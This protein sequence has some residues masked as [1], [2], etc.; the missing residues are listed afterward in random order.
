M[1]GKYLLKIFLG[2]AIV[3]IIACES[4]DDSPESSEQPAVVEDENQEVAPEEETE[5]S[6]YY[7]MS[8]Q[9][10][11]QVCGEAGFRY[12]FDGFVV[13]ECGACHHEDNI[14][15][16]SAFAQRDD[17]A[18]SFQV[19]SSGVVDSEAFKKMV[20]ENPLCIECNLIEGDPLLD[21]IDEYWLNPA[22]CPQ[23]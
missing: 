9:K 14:Y 20:R 23:E 1:N 5:E 3:T 19:I 6:K 2:A 21:D 18:A 10:P 8:G 11:D 22:I 12:L 17:F 15:D 7:P 13:P 4:K 16:V